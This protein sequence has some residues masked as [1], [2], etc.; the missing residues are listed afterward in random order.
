NDWFGTVYEYYRND[1]LNANTWFNNRDLP[2]DPGTGKAQKAKLNQYQQGIALGGPIVKNKAFF[3]V[4]YED[5]R[6][7]SA[8]TVTRVVL[9]PE[10][11]NGIFSYNAG[12]AVRQVNLLQLA[13][14]NGQ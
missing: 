8:S 6:R 14:A 1:K 4:N 10:A 12:T 7:P 5:E 13:A 3:F 9:T 11:M 2:P